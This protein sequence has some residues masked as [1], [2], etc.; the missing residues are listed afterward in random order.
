MQKGFATLE[1][2]L[3]TFIIVVIF[4]VAVPNANRMID[5]VALDYETKKIYTD[6]RFMQSQG[7]MTHMFD[8]H[9]YTESETPIT[10]I[11]YPKRYILRNNST[12][13]IHVEHYFS[14]GVTASQKNFTEYWQIQFDDMGKVTPAESGT[15]KLNSRLGKNS[16]I[17]FDS[18]GRFRGGLTD[19]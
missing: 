11:V 15:L 14:H 4:S 19:E 5:R 6:L 13:E 16:Y 10:L 12:S 7:R 9:F 8:S 1:I 18:V 2:I 3:M 17:I